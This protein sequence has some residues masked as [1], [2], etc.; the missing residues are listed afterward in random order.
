MLDTRLSMW[1]NVP[2]AHDVA[3]RGWLTRTSD[4]SLALYAVL[5]ARLNP[6]QFKTE[7]FAAFHGMALSAKT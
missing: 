4:T 2:S 6:S 1:K 5:V 7:T 3:F